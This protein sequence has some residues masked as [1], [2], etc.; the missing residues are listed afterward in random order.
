MENPTHLIYKSFIEYTKSIR[1]KRTDIVTLER[2]I[3]FRRLRYDETKDKLKY[4]SDFYISRIS[5]DDTAR[6]NQLKPYLKYMQN[7][8]IGGGFAAYIAGVTDTYGDVDI[9]KPATEIFPTYHYPG[10][11]IRLDEFGSPI[12][13]RV[14]RTYAETQFINYLVPDVIKEAPIIENAKYIISNFDLPVCSFGIF[15]EFSPSGKPE[16]YILKYKKPVH[17]NSPIPD[18]NRVRKYLDRCIDSYFK[19]DLYFLNSLCLQLYLK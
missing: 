19:E 13:F 14:N 4:K 3:T 11:E 17:F 2:K 8:I 5:P 9:Y 7:N 16:W 6:I 18:A 1:I 10:M 12:V 15:C